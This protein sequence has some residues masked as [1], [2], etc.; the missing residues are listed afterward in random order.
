MSDKFDVIING[1]K[2][3]YNQLLSSKKHTYSE[4][5]KKLSLAGIYLFS[6]DGEALYVGRTNNIKQRLQ[7]H[8]RNNH[9]QATF[10]F[11]L[12]RHET[13]NIKASYTQ[14]GSRA[15]LLKDDVF[16]TAFNQARENIRLM[17][18]QYVEENDPVSQTILEVYAAFESGAKYNNFD[19][20]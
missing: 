10:A 6:K 18:I 9:N 1:V 16:K 13:G 3:K 5:P 8:A 2:D 14:K 11:L 4:I 15:D 17:D 20:H 7:H 19:N 12:A